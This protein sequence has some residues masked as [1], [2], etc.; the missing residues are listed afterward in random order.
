MLIIV[1][2]TPPF[3]VNTKN[4]NN[5]TYVRLLS[6]SM[7]IT[8]FS[9]AFEQVT[10]INTRVANLK[11]DCYVLYVE[12]FSAIQIYSVALDENSSLD[13]C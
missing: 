13:V 4:N 3:S 7:N 6:Q 8:K 1:K 2:F 5:I 10:E 9:V 12:M 11:I